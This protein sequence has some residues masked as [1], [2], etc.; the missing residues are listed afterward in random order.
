VRATIVRPIMMLVRRERLLGVEGG[1]V[2]SR[3]LDEIEGGRIGR[4]SGR[5]SYPGNELARR[6]LDLSQSA[7]T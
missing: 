5:Y 6:K 2:E 4:V 7:T 3:V 1:G